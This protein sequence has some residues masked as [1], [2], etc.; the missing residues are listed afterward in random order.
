MLKRTRRV[1]TPEEAER[2]AR[3]GGTES[4]EAKKPNIL[5]RLLLGRRVGENRTT[6]KPTGR[7]PEPVPEPPQVPTSPASRRLPPTPVV[8]PAR[9]Q[10]NP[11]RKNPPH[12][13]YG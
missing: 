3:P 7:A 10:P 12:D 4:V 9:A 11:S 5:S 2:L 13:S 8:E 6:A 1:L